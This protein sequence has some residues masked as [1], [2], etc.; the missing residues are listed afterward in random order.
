MQNRTVIYF[1]GTG[2][3][4]YTAQRIASETDA[5]LLS[6]A[7][8][9]RKNT[10]KIDSDTVI[11]VFP[12]FIWQPPTLVMDFIRKMQMKPH[13]SLYAL[14]TYGGMLSRSLKVLEKTA[15]ESGL[16]YKG[17]FAVNLPGNAQTTYDVFP[18][19]KQEKMFS[20]AE[21]AF[22]EIADAIK[23]K[24]ATKSKTN[25]GIFGYLFT[26]SLAPKMIAGIHEAD[27]GF[28]R[29][30]ACTNCG[31]CE[32]VCPVHNLSIENGVFNY[33]HRCELCLACMQWCPEK[34]LQMG[35][36]SEGFGRYHHP[37]IAQKDMLKQA[38]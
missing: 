12:V 25:L 4:L 13:S 3:S 16:P 38:E 2:N 20:N 29:T 7:S 22:P 1:S 23:S 5:N 37:K 9:V 32:K 15:R 11:L 14:C 27:K 28:Y 24:R 26:Y 30:D 33:S 19:E 21:D 17:G 34:A 8:L 31:I 18:K 36:K 35:K 10:Y 6:M